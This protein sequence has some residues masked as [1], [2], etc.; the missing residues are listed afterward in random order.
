MATPDLQGQRL[1]TNNRPMQNIQ[2][3]MRKRIRGIFED[4][5]QPT[6]EERMKRPLLTVEHYQ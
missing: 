1:C 6:D 3:Y 4:R 2:L 5:N